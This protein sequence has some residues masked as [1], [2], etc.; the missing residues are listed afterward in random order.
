MAAYSVANCRSHFAKHNFIMSSGKLA[1][2]SKKMWT[3]CE[4]GI[5]AAIKCDFS[6]A[7]WNKRN[8]NHVTGPWYNTEHSRI[9]A[10][11]ATV[12]NE[13]IVAQL[14]FGVLIRSTALWGTRM[15][16]KSEYFGLKIMKHLVF[17]ECAFLAEIF[18]VSSLA[19]DAPGFSTSKS[20]QCH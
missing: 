16:T 13:E 10:T 19:P 5:R 4:D 9:G 1:D 18:L 11:A 6:T 12:R 15:L 3:V 7:D 2:I 20:I 14:F 8:E 17:S